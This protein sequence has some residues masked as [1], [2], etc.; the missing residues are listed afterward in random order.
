MERFITQKLIE[1]KDQQHRKPLILWGARQ[2]GKTWSV[3]DFGRRHFDGTIHH[4]DLEKHPDWHGLFEKNLEA[5]RIL[6]ELELLINRSIIQGKDLL[7]LDEIQSCPKAIMALRYFFEETP[8][9]HVIAAGSLLEFAVQDV[10]FPVGRVQTLDMHPMGFREFLAAAGKMKLADLLIRPPQK[11][12]ETVHQELL[13]QLRLY[14]FVGGMPESIKRYSETGRVRDAF[15]VQADLINTF[16]QDFLKYAPLADK[17]C[18]HSVL[19]STARNVGRQIKYS[20]LS[21]GF[22]NPT[23]KKAFFLLSQARLFRKVSSVSQPAVPF[24]A[25][26]SDS[27]FKA[28]FLDIGLM[29]QLC[30]LPVDMEFNKQDLLSIY[31]GAL[32]EQFAGQELLASG[33]T[34]LYYWAREQKSSTAEV[35]YLLAREGRAIPV[36]VKSGPAGRLRSMHLFMDLS[37]DCPR[38]VVLSC[39]PYA[40]LPE[41]KLVFLPLYYACSL[42]SDISEGFAPA[43]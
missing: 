33:E 40:E 25:S 38:G 26:A 6:S 20:R 3:L 23:I 43:G 39:A 27:K 24:G 28:V 8:D 21:E 41:Q 35:D 1:W 17:Q 42:G 2:V 22:T 32:A 36:E 16:R 18:L 13:D 12:P 37:P 7:F 34:D 19:V 14:L 5:R 29:Q 9:L 31:E 15:E 30:G 11:V 10:S 4:I